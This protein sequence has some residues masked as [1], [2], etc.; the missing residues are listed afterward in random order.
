MRRL[1]RRT[2]AYPTNSPSAI[3]GLC[4]WFRSD[5]GVTLG[6]GGVAAWANQASLTGSANDL[7][8]SN[9]AN[10]PSLQAV[11]VDFANSPGVRFQSANSDVLT[12]GANAFRTGTGGNITTWTIA[13]V[14]AHISDVNQGIA[15]EWRAD[16]YPSSSGAILLQDSDGGN[17]AGIASGAGNVPAG[18]GQALSAGEVH[19]YI[20]VVSSTS[21][22]ALYEDGVAVGTNGSSPSPSVLDAEEFTLGG[23]TSGALCND[24]SIAEV[25]CYNRALTAGEIAQLDAYLQRHTA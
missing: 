15:V 20:F 21:D 19:R 9:S 8:Q 14:L 25:C 1:G 12:S 13:A 24:V 7:A 5:L 23:R 16:S 6:T 3:S 17:Y 11:G 22:L 4:A 18:P 10:R 2:A